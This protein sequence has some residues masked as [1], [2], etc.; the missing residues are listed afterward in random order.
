MKGMIENYWKVALRNLIRLRF[1]TLINLFGLALGL[2]IAMLIG[3]YILHELRYDKFHPGYERIYRLA[4]KGDLSGQFFNVPMSSA[5]MGQALADEYDEIAAATRLLRVRQKVMVQSNQEG[6][7]ENRMF[8][9]NYAFFQVF[10]YDLL[11][12]NPEKVLASPYQVVITESMAHKYFGTDN[13][14]GQIIVFNQANRYTISGVVAD[15]PSCSHLQFDFLLSASSLEEDEALYGVNNWTTFAYHT[16]IKFTD[17]ALPKRFNLLL[18]DYFEKASGYDL[19]A[20]HIRI[21]PYLQ[22][23]TDI[24]LHSHLPEELSDNGSIATLYILVVVALFILGIACFNYVNLATAKSSTRAREVA[25]RKLVGATRKQLVGQF[26]SEA[27]LIVLLAGLIALFATEMLLPAFNK[28]AHTSIEFSGFLHM[29][30]LGVWCICIV[31][32]GILA[33]TYPAFF[34]AAYKPLD[35]LKGNIWGQRNRKSFRSS[36]VVFQFSVAVV[37][38]IAT[39]MVYRQVNYVRTQNLGF[40]K[41]EV[42]VLPVLDSTLASRSK[43]L[44]NALKVVPGVEHVT[45]SSNIPGNGLT[46]EGFNAEGTEGRTVL[47]F[48]FKADVDYVRAM[49]LNIKKGRN[50]TSAL[51]DTN[52]VLVNETLVTKMGWQN[53]IG[54]RLIQEHRVFHVV[55]VIQDMHFNSLHQ[56][57]EPMMIMPLQEHIAYVSIKLHPD[58]EDEALRQI[59][60]V[61]TEFDS[62]YPFQYSLLEDVYNKLYNNEITVGRMLLGFALLALFIACLGL[63]GLSSFV[64]EQRTKEIGIRKAMGASVWDIVLKLTYDFARWVFL[65]NLIGWPVAYAILSFWLT[66]FQYQASMP[67]WL[68]LN[69]AAITFLVSIA[70]VN[71]QA[72]KTAF[73]DPVDALRDE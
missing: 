13:V 34:L 66:D 70:T 33:G 56:A 18:E 31:I 3:F 32:I 5:P 51:R 35:V 7:Y 54:K 15:P 71:Y 26:L 38:I 45:A 41:N 24:H 57:V 2:T 6:H 47:I 55:G 53:P 43:S 1:Y 63:L 52:A 23:L 30:T 25:V 21:I 68:Y 36:L 64:T 50:F 37:L 10:G 48:S 61:W 19:A 22:P 20:E 59:Q 49:G 46:G 42:V 27:M 44:R 39:A 16:Y 60:Q 12:G 14:L 67:I 28:V 72:L 65:A 17:D 8:Y 69:A 58:L 40:D 9:A 73:M 11:Q 29:Q 4:T 62:R